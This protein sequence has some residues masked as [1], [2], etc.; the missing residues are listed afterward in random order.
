MLWSYGL[1]FAGMAVSLLVF[2]ALWRVAP[3]GRELLARVFAALA[4][5]IYYWFKL[6]VVLGLS[7]DGSHALVS[8]KG[9]AP[10][11]TI[12]ALRLGMA[13]LLVGLLLGRAAVRGWSPR[14]PMTAA[15]T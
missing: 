10:D 7:G 15:T 5:A 3:K 8:L 11:W 14:P 12:W 6:P 13:A 4:I 2:L 9:V 1:S